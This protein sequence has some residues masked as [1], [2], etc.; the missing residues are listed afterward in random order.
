MPTLW[1]RS[2]WQRTRYQACSR[3]TRRSRRSWCPLCL[4]LELVR[5]QPLDR[6]GGHPCGASQQAPPGGLL[7]EK[8]IR[9]VR[10]HD[11]VVLPG[12]RPGRPKDVLCNRS[13]DGKLS[14]TQNGF[15]FGRSTDDAVIRKQE[16]QAGGAGLFG[17]QADYLRFLRGILR[18]DPKHASDGGPAGLLKPESYAELFKPSMPTSDKSECLRQ[19][20]RD[21]LASQVL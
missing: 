21:G 13:E 2:T 18:S 14:V 4:S 15:G 11:H 6:L 8:H 12:H 19:D 20:R 3:P 1:S 16:L 7:P 10:H 5:L 9:A 17:T